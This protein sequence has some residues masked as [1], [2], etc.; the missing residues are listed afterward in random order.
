MAEMR[1]V[2]ERMRVES[3]LA[4][5]EPAFKRQL[6]RFND[7]ILISEDTDGVIAAL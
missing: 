3:G 6:V 4:E 1:A 7:K 2:A 5:I